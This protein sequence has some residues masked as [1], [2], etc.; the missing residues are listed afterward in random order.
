M[1]APRGL[2]CNRLLLYLYI[3]IIWFIINPIQATAAS[4]TTKTCHPLEPSS[5]D[6][7]GTAPSTPTRMPAQQRHTSHAPLQRN[8]ASARRLTPLI[9]YVKKHASRMFCV[10]MASMTSSSA[11]KHT[12]S[13]S[14][15]TGNA[16]QHASRAARAALESRQLHLINPSVLGHRRQSVM[17]LTSGCRPSTPCSICFS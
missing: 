17:P 13:R 16:L 1:T 15:P 14:E 9:M 12:M 6:S 11:S 4:F 5:T 2:E 3:Y 8:A 7:P 10:P